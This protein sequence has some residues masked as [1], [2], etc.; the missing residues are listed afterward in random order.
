M[1]MTQVHKAEE[2]RTNPKT[3][4]IDPLARV[5]V[6]AQEL[7]GALSDAASKRGEV[8]KAE[9]QSIP[10]KATAVMASVKESLSAQS[11]V[12]RKHLEEALKFLETTEKHAAASLENT[13]HAFETS[14]RR[15]VAD[16]RGAAQKVSEAVAAKRSA[17]ST[18]SHT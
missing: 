13:G 14:V 5:R 7:H 1:T 18:K 6:A 16:A 15:A 12:T 11:D 3:N 8:M 17:E 4:A 9:L 10:K 2:A